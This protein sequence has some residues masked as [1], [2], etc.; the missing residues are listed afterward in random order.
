MVYVFFS[1]V[2]SVVLRFSF[3]F[4]KIVQSLINKRSCVMIYSDA[5][6][7]ISEKHIKIQIQLIT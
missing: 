1:Q 7:G 2:C 4:A 5:A 6:Q 3:I